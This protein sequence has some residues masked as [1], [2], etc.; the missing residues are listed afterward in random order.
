MTT[1]PIWQHLYNQGCKT[2]Q[3][4]LERH[5]INKHKIDTECTFQP[6]VKQNKRY[7]VHSSSNFFERNNLWNQQKLEKKIKEKEEKVYSDLR[8]CTFKPKLNTRTKRMT[9]V[10][11]K[12]ALKNDRSQK[13]LKQY[14]RNINP[15]YSPIKNTKGRSPSPRPAARSNIQVPEVLKMIK[16]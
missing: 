7:L 9:E 3:E 6:M 8:E 11:S 1:E 14:N 15:Y 16:S 12:S 10:G 4:I 2:K 5:E 13:Q